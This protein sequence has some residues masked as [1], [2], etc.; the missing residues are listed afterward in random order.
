MRSARRGASAAASGKR[1]GSPRPAASRSAGL[2]RQ[3]LRARWRSGAARRRCAASQSSAGASRRRA[4]VAAPASAAVARHERAGDPSAAPPTRC[5]GSVPALRAAARPAPADARGGP[6]RHRRGRATQHGSVSAAARVTG[7]RRR[8]A[9]TQP[10]GRSRSHSVAHARP[11]VP[12]AGR[13]AR[14]VSQRRARGRLVEQPADRSRER[15]WSSSGASRPWTPS[16]QDRRH[17]ARVGRR[18]PADRWRTPRAPTSACCRCRALNVDVVRPRSSAAISSGAT[19]PANVTCCS[20]VSRASARS[21][22]SSRAAADQ[23]QRRVRPALLDTSETRA[24]CRR[25]C[26]AARSCASREGAAA[27]APRAEAEALEVDDVRDRL[28]ARCRSARTRR[29]GTATAR[30]AVRRCAMH[31]AGDPRAPQMIGRLAA[32]VVQDRPDAPSDAR[33]QHGR[34]RRQQERA[35]TTPKTRGRRRRAAARA[36]AAGR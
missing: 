23:R 36:T 34:Q 5:R 25:R 6:F 17:A 35:C 12:R 28:G 27:A 32:A 10:R 26:R 31:G 18:R 20:R 19:R 16:R 11:R 33:Q 15:S 22:R 2:I 8:L 13:A 29:P 3:A 21:A 7:R 30:R 9:A 1:R 24:A 14:R 4:R